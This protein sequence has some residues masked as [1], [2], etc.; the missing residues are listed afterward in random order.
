MLRTYL[1]DQVHLALVLFCLQLG[2][3]DVRRLHG[4]LLPLLVKVQLHAS[5]R[6]TLLLRPALSFL[7]KVQACSVPGHPQHARSSLHTLVLRAVKVRSTVRCTIYGS[8]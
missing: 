3:F 7:L 2:R 6:C 5:S 1:L 8:V 4:I